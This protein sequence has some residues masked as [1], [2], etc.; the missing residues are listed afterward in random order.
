MI[1]ALL[2]LLRLALLGLAFVY[3]I[4]TFGIYWGVVAGVILLGTWTRVVWALEN[5]LRFL[6]GLDMEPWA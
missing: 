5:V 4:S 1:S 6:V 2:Y 3:F